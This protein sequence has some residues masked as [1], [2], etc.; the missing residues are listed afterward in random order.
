MAFLTDLDRTY[1]T[2]EDICA[3][4][5][6]E[7]ARFMGAIV[8]PV[9]Q[10]SLFVRPNAGNGVEDAGYV[11][12]RASNPTIDIAERKIAA[13]EGGEG[14]LCFA[15]GMGAISSA[16]MHFA[17]AGGHIVL[18]DSAYGCTLG[19]IRDYLS[20]RFAVEFTNV[21]GS[22]VE[23]IENAIRPNTTLIYLE[24]PSSMLFRMQDIEQIARIARERGIG[25][26]M[27]NSYSTPLYQ[28]PLKYGI[29]I[30]CHTASKYLGGHSDIV[31]GALASRDRDIITSIQDYERA[32]FGNNMDPHAASM[33]I[34]GIRT[35]PVRLP[36]HSANAEK[37]VRF[38][39][40]DPRI[41]KVNYPGSATYG[42][43][44]LFHKYMKRAS[45]LLSFIP[46]GT[47]EQ[48]RAF[49]A[50]L[51]YF[52]NGVSWGGFESLCVTSGVLDTTPEIG[53]KAFV[54]RMHIGLENV[55]TL[56]DD[57]SQALEVLPKV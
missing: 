45:G 48:I 47:E 23:E 57:I 25:T 52:Q 11:Y 30:V 37:V 38:L 44:D 41:I 12:T 32:W 14:A 5:G 15:S 27:D 31:A 6:D 9:F 55:D 3:H 4:V 43:N 50:R 26:I 56:I 34:R 53:R 13:L 16:I 18:V 36:Q 7:Y 10:N 2:P 33:L 22:S 29:D 1:T 51:R 40:S 39:E 19:L 54:V 8:P 24:S 35:L 20:K 21:N 28:Q 49:C 42:Q 17:R 46:K